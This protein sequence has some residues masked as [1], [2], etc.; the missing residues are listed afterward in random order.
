[1]LAGTASLRAA[2]SINWYKVAGG[3]VNMDHAVNSTDGLLIGQRFSGLIQDPSGN[4]ILEAD[5]FVLAG[6]PAV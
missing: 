6:N 5:T 1:M 3:D 4:W 2:G